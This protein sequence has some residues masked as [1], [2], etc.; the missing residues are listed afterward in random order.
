MDALVFLGLGL[1][2]VGLA[3]SF[4]VGLFL[5]LLSRGHHP[6]PERKG[7]GLGAFLGI[8]S[9]IL[10]IVSTSV[11]LFKD[12]TGKTEAAPAYPYQPPP[13][14]YQPPPQPTPQPTPSYGLNCC[15]PQGN[16][17]LMTG[18]ALMNSPCTCMTM[19]GTM[20]M[21]TVCQ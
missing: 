12:C 21:G 3:V 19:M 9:T 10:G 5:G 8:V 18:P 14:P 15:S 16:C 2:L 7:G 13:Q 4:K 6:P 1:L 17:P 20:T 11:G